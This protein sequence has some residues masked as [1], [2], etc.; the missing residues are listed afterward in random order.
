MYY[1]LEF[2]AERLHFQCLKKPV[3]NCKQVL[4]EILLEKQLKGLRIFI[5]N[6]V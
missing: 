2:N 6:I 3:E 4:L 1:I 5:I